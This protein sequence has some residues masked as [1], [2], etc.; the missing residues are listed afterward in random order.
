MK[1]LNLTDVS[2]YVEQNIG[3]FHQKRIQ[4]LDSLKL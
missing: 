4:S 1:K 2:R 3:A